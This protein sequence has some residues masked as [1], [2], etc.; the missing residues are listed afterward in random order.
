[1]AEADAKRKKNF[2]EELKDIGER[3]DYLE[4]V[5]SLPD[6]FFSTDEI[7]SKAFNLMTATFK[8][9]RQ[10]VK[11]IATSLGSLGII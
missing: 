6:E 11:Y 7:Q 8:L 10:Q 3:L 1:M 4:D 2:L 9:L 5:K